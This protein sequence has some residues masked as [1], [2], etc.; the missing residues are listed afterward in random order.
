MTQPKTVFRFTAS[1]LLASTAVF[2]PAA[3]AATSD[4]AAEMSTTA[5]SSQSDGKTHVEYRSTADRAAFDKFGQ[6][7]HVSKDGTIAE[8]I[9]KNERR[10]D[11]DAA[12]RIDEFVSLA[13]NADANR[14]NPPITAYGNET[15]VSGWGPIQRVYISHTLLSKATKVLSAGGGAAGIVALLAAEGISGPAGWVAAG[16]TA[17]VGA[18]NLCDWN[19]QGII[20]WQVPGLPVPACTPQS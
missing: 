9:P 16:L 10:N 6:Y 4:T 7:I 15:K 2:A 5:T 3:N 12:K 8:T 1:V 11:P 13:N 19:D 14:K 20:I 18:G 17:L